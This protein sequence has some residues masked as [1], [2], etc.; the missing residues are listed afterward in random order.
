MTNPYNKAPLSKKEAIVRDRA[1]EPAIA[2]PYC[3]T[4][5]TVGDLL[6][7]IDD[8]CIGRRPEH[9]L[10][11]WIPR[12]DALAL[13]VPPR[14]LR[15]WVTAGWVRTRGKFKLRRYNKRDLVGELAIRRRRRSR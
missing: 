7:H 3:E 1:R 9:R 13:G 8:R 15:R 11:K 2:C 12:K 14:T 4:K 6:G 10:S 5:T